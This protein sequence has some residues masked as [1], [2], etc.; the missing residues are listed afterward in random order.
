MTNPLTKER[1]KEI[2]ARCEAATEGEWS[3]PVNRADDSVWWFKTDQHAFNNGKAI[4]TCH[5]PGAKANAEL[6]AHAR[7]D[8]PDCLAEIERLRA[9][10]E[11]IIVESGKVDISNWP[12]PQQ[13]CQSI[14]NKSL[15]RDV[16][17]LP[18]K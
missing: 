13:I 14:A 16:N 4:A 8:L 5:G 15:G 6:L 17:G 2:K 10:M 9:D 3:I 12:T 7:R 1:L 11:E 18:K